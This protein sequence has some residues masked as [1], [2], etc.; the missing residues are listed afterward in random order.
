[1]HICEACSK[2]GTT[3]CEKN[4]DILL[5]EA[6]K[7]RI[8]KHFG[9][10]DFWEFRSPVSP[11]YLEQDDDPNW[12]GYILKT[13]G[14]RLVMKLSNL[15][16]CTLLTSTGCP[17]PL[18]IR[19]L[20]CRLHPYCF[21]E[22]ELQNIESECPKD[23]YTSDEDLSLQLGMDKNLAESWRVQLY[24]ELRQQNGLE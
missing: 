8:Q 20:V 21:T 3:C 11:E 16:N 17:L 10:N 13:D 15:G 19:P 1:M 4:R 9:T 14:T 18:N 23:L 5:T 22:T 2:R 12:L 7:I 6:D 24:K